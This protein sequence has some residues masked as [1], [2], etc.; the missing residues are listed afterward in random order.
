M[1]ACVADGLL[2]LPTI[3]FYV[4]SMPPPPVVPSPNCTTLPYIHLQQNIDALVFYFVFLNVYIYIFFSFPHTSKIN[5][6][7]GIFEFFILKLYVLG[8]LYFHPPLSHFYRNSSEE[9]A[10]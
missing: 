7:G 1:L 6:L 8:C 4:L 3:I 5:T 9:L 2:M 10:Q